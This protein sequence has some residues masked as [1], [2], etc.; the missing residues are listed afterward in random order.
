MV[1]IKILN[2]LFKIGNL[3][4]NGVKM[5]SLRRNLFFNTGDFVI[6]IFADDGVKI[7]LDDELVIDAWK[8]YDTYTMSK[9]L[10]KGKTY[11]IKIEYF[12]DGGKS[13]Y[14]FGWMASAELDE[15][16]VFLPEGTWM[17]VWTGKEYVGPKTITVSHTLETSP[18]F[19][20]QGAIVPLVSQAQNT[21]K[22]D[23]SK[24][25]FNGLYIKGIYGREMHETW[26]KMSAM[27]QGGLDISNIITHRMDVRDFEE[28]FAAMNSGKAGKVIL[29]WTN[30]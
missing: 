29:D 6:G 19:V 14:S 15:R 27:L 18:I 20:R 25:I 26:Y 1:F 12:E 9:K 24:V 28:G 2:S 13:H 30:L 11:N 8:V 4:F 21:A 3:F 16:T 22:I 5:L 17:D 10:E 23:W 7:W